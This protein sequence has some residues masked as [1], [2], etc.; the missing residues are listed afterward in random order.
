MALDALYASDSEPIR[1][2]FAA[3][4]KGIQVERCYH[5]EGLMSTRN[6]WE[7]SRE[8]PFALYAFR[9]RHPT[10]DESQW[11]LISARRNIV[12]LSTHARREFIACHRTITV[13]KP[14]ISRFAAV[15]VF[16][17]FTWTS[18]DQP[19]SIQF[20]GECI[21]HSFVTFCFPIQL[22]PHWRIQSLSGFNQID[23]ATDWASLSDCLCHKKT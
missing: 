19:E 1:R 14:S 8:I 12:F 7:N 6:K 23:I 3:K 9:G 4:W 16:G 17:C 11:N 18:T 21:I 22:L 10:I 5:F 2:R 13:G 15:V 20:K